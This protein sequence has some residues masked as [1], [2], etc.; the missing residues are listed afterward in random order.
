[1]FKAYWAS[2]WLDDIRNTDHILFVDEAA[3]QVA[4]GQIFV[5]D[6]H[7]IIFD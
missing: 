7:G 3:D 2:P 5:R 1:M 4:A 6:T